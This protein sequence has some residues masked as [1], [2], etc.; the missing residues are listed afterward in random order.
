MRLAAFFSTRPTG[1]SE[2]KTCYMTATAHNEAS[3]TRQKLP[4]LGAK[5]S[6]GLWRFGRGISRYSLQILI[7]LAA[8][9]I[10]F[11]VALPELVK[12]YVNKTLSEIDG[13][14]GRVED[15][16]M[17]LWRGAYSISGVNIVKT[18]GDVPVPFFKA[19]DIDFSVEWRALFQGALVAKILFDTPVINFVAGPT[20][21]TSQVGVD[22]PWLSVIKEL[23]PL[24]INR[25][26]VLNGSAHYR[27]F[28]ATPKVDL[29]LDRTH[30]L[31]LNLTNSNKLSKSLVGKIEVQGRA[32]ESSQYEV[33]TKID[34]RTERATFDVSAKLDPVPLEKFN[35]YA[36]AYGKF[37]FQKGTM[38]L[39]LELAA[40]DG[41]LKGYA[42]PILDDIAVIDLRDINNPLK[43]AWEGLVGGVLRLFR[44]QPHDRFATRIPIE[45]T[46]KNP[47]TPILPTL[48]NILK[49][50]FFKAY[51]NDFEGDIDLRDA[52]R[53]DGKTPEI[54]KEDP[55]ARNSRERPEKKDD[56]R[57]SETPTASPS[58]R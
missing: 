22:K 48:G 23:F 39:V 18:D 15:V 5:L 2:S 49:N 8:L 1:H 38:A 41:T 46:M 56:A 55:E 20:E 37:H 35:D 32:F 45:G 10:A 3:R 30:I 36:E 29:V 24:N 40:S 17:H 42:K 54:K 57:K 11:R 33:H 21:E 43:L 26:E 13:Y 27:D 14:N 53:A 44:N 58:K 52:Q 7:V 6:H 4:S 28:H 51:Q 16:D 25:F 31:G 34:P 12:R 47:E 19:R 9:L 50:A